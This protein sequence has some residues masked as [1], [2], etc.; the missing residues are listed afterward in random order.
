[1]PDVLVKLPKIK[2]EDV[3]MQK[4]LQDG[5]YIESFVNKYPNYTNAQVSSLLRT[6]KSHGITLNRRIVDRQIRDYKH[7]ASKPP[8]FDLEYDIQL[9][10]A[11]ELIRTSKKLK[12]TV[13]VFK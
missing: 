13:K 10:K 8:L 4:K 1:E 3:Y 2:F 9:K 5:K 11:V 12:R 7:R 6:L